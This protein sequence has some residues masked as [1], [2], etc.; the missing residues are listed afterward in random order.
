MKPAVLFIST[1]DQNSATLRSTIEENFEVFHYIFEQHD[2]AAFLQ[3][4]NDTFGKTGTKLCAIYGGYPSF[5]PIGGLTR[6]LIEHEWFPKTLQCIA[7]CSR[8]VN[9][10]DLE[11]LK[12]HKI[13]LYNYNDE[14]DGISVEKP[15]L[16]G[17]DVADCVLWHVLEGFRKFSLQQQALRQH[18]DTFQARFCVTEQESPCEYEFGHDL[19]P[20]ACF[21]ESPRGEKCLI[22]GLGSVGKQVGYKLQHG[23]GMEIHYSKRTKDDKVDWQFHPFDETLDDTLKQFSTVVIALPGTPQTEHLIDS[24][25]LSH[26]SPGLVLVNVGR[27]SIL[28]QDAVNAALER[29]HLRHLGID[30]FYQEPSVEQSLLN[31]VTNVTITPHIASSTKSVF[32]QSC[33]YALQNIIRVVLYGKEGSSR[34][35]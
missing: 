24:K 2:K 31:N 10:I 11:A 12:D 18:G 3:Y 15:G 19:G 13:Q 20:K 6:D 21:A 5:A 23:L 27:G 32:I 29:G 9:G 28:D 8:G 4:L 16:V 17:N 22:L 7:L 30:V 26:C 34:V 33:E 35:V 14:L 1:P 25:F